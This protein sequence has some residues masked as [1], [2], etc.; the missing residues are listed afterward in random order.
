VVNGVI[1]FSLLP[2]FDSRPT[3]EHFQMRDWKATKSAWP[4]THVMYMLQVQIK[5]CRRLATPKT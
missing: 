4:H 5:G 1:I 3:S 2:L